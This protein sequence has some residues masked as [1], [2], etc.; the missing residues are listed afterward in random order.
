MSSVVTPN[1]LFYRTRRLFQHFG[2]DSHGGIHRVGDNTDA[3]LWAG[4][5]NLLHQVLNDAGIHIKQVGTIHAGLT[6]YARGD[7]HHISAFQRRGS[8]FTGKSFNFTS[9]GI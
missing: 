1:S 4:F 3:G 7:Q 6:R 5:G 2:G 9:V 8:I